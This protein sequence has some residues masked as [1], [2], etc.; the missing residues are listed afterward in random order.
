MALP[1]ANKKDVNV[2]SNEYNQQLTVN[3]ALNRL[4]ENDQYIENTL[5]G[6]A[7][8]ALSAD[9]SAVSGDLQTLSA[10][11]TDSADYSTSG[12]TKIS[13][14]V[15]MQYG[16]I[17]L[18]DFTSD[19]ATVTLPQAFTTSVFSVNVTPVND[20][21][22]DTTVDGVFVGDVSLSAFKIGFDTDSVNYFIGI[23][24]QA[25]GI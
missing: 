24:W 22:P 14:T 7:I 25:I 13:D 12:Y 4:F 19:L 17:P 6:G 18:S 20:G 10:T 9:L 3:R 8:S 21:T 11:I 5:A 15:I 1:W 23:Y 16:F 2:F